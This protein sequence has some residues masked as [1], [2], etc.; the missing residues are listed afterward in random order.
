[1][2]TRLRFGRVAVVDQA[3]TSVDFVRGEC[4]LMRS[5]VVCA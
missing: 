3:R 4:A 5:L 1:M 2:A